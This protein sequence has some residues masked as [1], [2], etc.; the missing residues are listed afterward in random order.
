MIDGIYYIP[1][2]DITAQAADGRTLILA[3]K[4]VPMLLVVARRLGYVKDEVKVGPT[5]TKVAEAQPPS[6][7][8]KRGK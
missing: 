7:K 5:E 6:V 1:D 4:G 3:H 2:E 8:R